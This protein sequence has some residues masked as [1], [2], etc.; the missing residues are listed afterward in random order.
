MCIHPILK[1]NCGEVLLVDVALSVANFA[2][3]LLMIF[4]KFPAA[5]PPLEILR[6]LTD[7]LIPKFTQTFKYSGMS[8][9]SH[10]PWHSNIRKSS[11]VVCTTFW[12][13][14][15][16]TRQSIYRHPDTPGYSGIG[17]TLQVACTHEK[18]E[19]RRRWRVLQLQLPSSSGFPPPLFLSVWRG[20]KKDKQA[21][22]AHT[23]EMFLHPL[24]INLDLP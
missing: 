2:C 19:R 13:P 16:S 7:I 24:A 18:E 23:P 8:N 1:Q 5:P 17:R 15:H 20:G 14:E 6:F 22:K 4:F 21:Q 11:L 10:K 12:Y 3:L 9:I